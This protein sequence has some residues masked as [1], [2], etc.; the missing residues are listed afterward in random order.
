MR[1][2]NY[3]HGIF[4]IPYHLNYQRFW[5]FI[6]VVWQR[7]LAIDLE[8]WIIS[9]IFLCLHLL[10]TFFFEALLCVYSEKQ[11]N[12]RLIGTSYSKITPSMT[13]KQTWKALTLTKL[14]PFAISSQW[15]IWMGKSLDK[16]C[17]LY[18]A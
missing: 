15:E 6:S 16:Y 4:A 13:W 2:K 18:L 3:V 9:S 11:P 12:A 10:G 14:S 1:T 7:S 8:S 17:I 5:T